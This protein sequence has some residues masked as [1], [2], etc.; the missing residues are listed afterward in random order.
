MEQEKVTHRRLVAD[1]S[2]LH[3][4]LLNLGFEE[5]KP[6]GHG[7]TQIRVFKKE[8]KFVHSSAKSLKLFTLEGPGDKEVVL[9]KGLT[10][11]DQLLKFFAKR[12]LGYT[13]KSKENE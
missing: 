4:E 13:I 12:G 11:H 6:I 3:E 2:M 7:Y 5:I 1:T 10:V 9:Y 8:K